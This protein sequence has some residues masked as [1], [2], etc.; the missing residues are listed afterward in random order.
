MSAMKKEYYAK[1]TAKT[2]A[3]KYNWAF[4]PHN[5]NLIRELIHLNKCYMTSKVLCVTFKNQ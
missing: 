3:A 1:T 4:S 5:N 2:V